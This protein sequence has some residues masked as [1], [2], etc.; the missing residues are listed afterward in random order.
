[1]VY[2]VY[3]ILH[4]AFVRTLVRTYVS[5]GEWRETLS[6]ASGSAGMVDGSIDIHI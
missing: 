3:P 6:C 4:Y 1:M 5:T 2:S